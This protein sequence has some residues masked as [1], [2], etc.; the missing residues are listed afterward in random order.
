MDPTQSAALLK[1]FPVTTRSER[2]ISL[3]AQVPQFDQLRG[4]RGTAQYARECFS[5]LSLPDEPG[6][7]FDFL[8]GFWVGDFAP[9]LERLGFRFRETYSPWHIAEIGANGVKFS[10]YYYLDHDNRAYNPETWRPG[11]YSTGK[12]MRV[13]LRFDLE[14]PAAVDPGLRDNLLVE[15]M[16]RLT[17]GTLGPESTV[18]LL[19]LEPVTLERISI[20]VADDFSLRVRTLPRG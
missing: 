17:E 19:P 10:V 1:A 8:K 20:G 18:S 2:D 3:A 4:P 16:I 14:N 7:R 6:R 9:I 11:Y 13:L 12:R 15:G 5:L